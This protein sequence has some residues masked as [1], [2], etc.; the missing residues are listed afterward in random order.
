MQSVAR[1]PASRRATFR[2]LARR[3]PIDGLEE[4]L[5]EGIIAGHPHMPEFRFR[6]DHVG[7]VITYLKSIQVR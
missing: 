4:V 6:A 2:T 5:D 1:A 3:Y 7:A